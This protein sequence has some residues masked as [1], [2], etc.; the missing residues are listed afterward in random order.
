MALLQAP[1]PAQLVVAAPPAAQIETPKP[2]GW[3]EELPYIELPKAALNH[4]KVHAINQ[5]GKV[6]EALADVLAL[7]GDE[8]VAV[9]GAFAA[10]L[11]KWQGLEA[12]SG[13]YEP[14]Y[15]PQNR[16]NEAQL[17]AFTMRF[18]ALQQQGTTIRSDLEAAV[19]AALGESRSR[20]LFNYADESLDVMFAS[21]GRR[22]RLITIIR[23]GNESGAVNYQIATVHD[24]RNIGTTF[25]RI[26]TLP[27]GTIANL[28]P[29]PAP[30]QAIAIRWHLNDRPR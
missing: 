7:T 21:Q 13:R 8:I 2:A 16:W 30:M 11:R 24:G 6:T 4:L 20:L 22:E 14:G 26:H 17:E 9:E 12:A 19:H 27:D 5:D 18:P 28:H 15:V 25:H 1:L 29:L 3:R 23:T 10:Q